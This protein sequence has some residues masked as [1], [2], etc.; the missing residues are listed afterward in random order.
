MAVPLVPIDP[1]QPEGQCNDE[2]DR[3]R[4]CREDAVP[5]EWADSA[6][7][8]LVCGRLRLRTLHERLLYL[9]G[10]SY[11]NEPKGRFTSEKTLA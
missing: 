10:E 9:C 6:R 1:V 3:K 4:G 2:D 5:I 11:S 8:G 7:T